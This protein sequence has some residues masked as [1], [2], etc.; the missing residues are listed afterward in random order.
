MP[1]LSALQ[2]RETNVLR[3]ANEKNLETW[4]GAES[5]GCSSLTLIS[6]SYDSDE[7]IRYSNV[8]LQSV[9]S[10]IPVSS[11]HRVTELG[12]EPR[13]TIFLFRTPQNNFISRHNYGSRFIRLTSAL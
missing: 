1:K 7:G 5:Y 4:R 3:L 6:L 8:F 10:H 9:L 13:K 2:S 12:S 11:G